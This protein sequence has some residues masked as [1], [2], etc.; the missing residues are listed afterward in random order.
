MNSQVAE[1]FDDLEQQEDA[2]SFSMWVFLATEVL[3]FG[4][5]FLAYIIYRVTYP[6]AFASA[7]KELNVMFGTVNTAILLTSS[8]SMALAVRAAR[9]KK[10]HVSALYLLTTFALGLSFLVIKAFEYKEDFEKGLYAGER[11]AL[12]NPH[13]VAIFYSLYYTMTGLHA[14]HMSIGAGLLLFFAWRTLREKATPNQIEV[15]GLY[16]HFVDLVWVFL[17]PLLYLIGVQG[18]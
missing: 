18:K 4:G 11:L 5:L 7:S 17:Y 2:A 13:G 6:D 9:S 10:S 12:G 15:L 3:F 1:Q 16:W 14:V 8:F